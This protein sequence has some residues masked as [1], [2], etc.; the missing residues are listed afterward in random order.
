MEIVS[1]ALAEI[2]EQKSY[3]DKE[4]PNILKQNRQ[5]GSRDRAFVAET[6]YD[7]VRWRRNY[8]AA[9][10]P[11]ESTQLKWEAIIYLSLVNNKSYTI[12]NPD[13]FKP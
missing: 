8:E 2:F 5:L 1:H 3:A 4:V 10:T 13:V 9:L 12:Q 6:I 7:V 11:E